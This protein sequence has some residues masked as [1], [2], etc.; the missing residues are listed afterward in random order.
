MRIL[1]FGVLLLS[2][3]ASKEYQY[4]SNPITVDSGSF[5]LLEPEKSRSD[6]YFIYKRNKQ[7]LV[8]GLPYVNEDSLHKLGDYELFILRKDFGE[9]R[10]EITDQNLV[11]PKLEDQKRASAEYLKV[12]KIIKNKTKQFDNNFSF[13]SPIESVITSAYGKRR[14]INNNERSPHMALDLRGAVG[15]EIFAPKTGKVVLAENHFYGGNKVILDHGGG[16]FTAYSHMSE[17]LVKLEDVVEAGTVIGLVGMTGRVTGPH[18]HWEVF[19]NENRIN[20]ELLISLEYA[21]D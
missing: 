19:L 2:S 13:Q 21:Q 17:I 3:C 9:S 6:G 15:R 4:I 10:I 20:P 1:L 12:R 8:Y 16:L 11:S 14:F 18:L 5:I 7:F